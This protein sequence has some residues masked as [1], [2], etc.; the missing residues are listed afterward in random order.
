M[1]LENG[2]KM[3]FRCEKVHRTRK[4]PRQLVDSRRLLIIQNIR[5]RCEKLFRGECLCKEVGY[6]QA[7]ERSGLLGIQDTAHPDNLSLRFA[8][9]W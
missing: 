3:T 5:E 2:E 9:L 6:V 4:I 7:F 8:F 1:Y